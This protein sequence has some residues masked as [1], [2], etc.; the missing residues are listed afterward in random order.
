[1]SLSYVLGLSLIAAGM[2]AKQGMKAGFLIIID[3]HRVIGDFAW[4]WTDFAYLV[5]TELNFDGVFRMVPH[6]MYTAG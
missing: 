1:M 4:Y 2:W 6:P 3:A 5:D